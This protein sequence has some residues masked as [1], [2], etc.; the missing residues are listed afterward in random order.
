M[1]LGLFSMPKN[2]LMEVYPPGLPRIGVYL[3]PLRLRIELLL[4][5]LLENSYLRFVIIIP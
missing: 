4:L 5:S 1:K 3:T 2:L